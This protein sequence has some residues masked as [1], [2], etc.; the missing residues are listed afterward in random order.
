M[1]RSIRS[2]L[3][4]LGIVG[5]AAGIGALLAQDAPPETDEAAPDD[6]LANRAVAALYLATGRPEAAEP[7]LQRAADRPVQTLKSSLALADYYGSLGRYDDAKTALAGTDISAIKA[8]MEKL[9]EESQ[10]L[11]QAIYEATQAEQAAGGAGGEQL[12]GR[13]LGRELAH[14]RDHRVLL[15]VVRDQRDARLGGLVHSGTRLTRTCSSRTWPRAWVRR[16]PSAGFAG[17][18]LRAIVTHLPSA[19]GKRLCHCCE[20]PS[21]AG[22]CQRSCSC[23][24]PF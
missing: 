3:I 8:A 21:P 7:Y 14:Q 10:S 5:A 15:L 20:P 11:G 4:A 2:L 9:G 1:R 13:Q 6:E 22:C 12:A 19:T 18:A 16:L 17:G 24:W 23:S